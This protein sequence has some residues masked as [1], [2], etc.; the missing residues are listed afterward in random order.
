MLHYVF[1]LMR[2]S[3]SNMPAC[4]HKTTIRWKSFVFQP[5]AVAYICLLGI[6]PC[7]T[8]QKRSMPC[9]QTVSEQVCLLLDAPGRCFGSLYRNESSETYGNWETVWSGWFAVGFST[10][11]ER[12]VTWPEKNEATVAYLLWISSFVM[13]GY[14]LCM[15]AVHFYILCLTFSISIKDVTTFLGLLDLFFVSFKLDWIHSS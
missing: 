7:V 5:I 14:L 15:F 10:V 2:H 12:P 13:S 1:Q 4:K 3:Y 11:C 6:S 9:P 8:F